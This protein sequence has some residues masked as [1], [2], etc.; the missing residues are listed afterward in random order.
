MKVHALT[1]RPTGSPLFWEQDSCSLLCCRG[2]PIT[3]LLA[4][5]DISSSAHVGRACPSSPSCRRQHATVNLRR[6]PK[7]I[8]RT[9]VEVLDICGSAGWRAAFCGLWFLATNQFVAL[10]SG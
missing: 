6:L 8:F 10:A 1:V 9:V 4:P 3:R 2:A 5:T 7:A